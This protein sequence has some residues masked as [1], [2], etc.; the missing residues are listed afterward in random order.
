MSP[1]FFMTMSRIIHVRNLNKA[2]QTP[3]QIKYCASFLCKLRGLMFRANIATDDGLL[4]A[5]KRDS[6]VDTS[7]HMLFMNF[8]IAVIWID[9]SMQIVDKAL[10][11]RWKPAY[12]PKAGARYILE[13]HPDRLDE[14]EIGNKVQFEDV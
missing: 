1:Y 5:Y 8:D 4:F 7:I 6:R 13:T 9:S 12:A 10:A 14:F 3:L 2:S 11:K